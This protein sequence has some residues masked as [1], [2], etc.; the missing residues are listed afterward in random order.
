MLNRKTKLSHAVSS[1]AI[2]GCALGS[3]GLALGGIHPAWAQDT[4]TPAADEGELHT[5]VVVAE[6]KVNSEQKTPIAMSVYRAEQLQSAG[7]TDLR[8]LGAV[9][10]DVQLGGARPVLTMRGIS[11]RDT[12]EIG[13][14][15]VVVATDGTYNNRSYA[16]DASMYD[17]DRVEILRGPQ[18]TLYGRNANGGLINIITNKPTEKREAEA[19]VDVGN[20]HALRL[21]AVLNIPLSETVQMRVAATTKYHQGYLNN[22]PLSADDEDT[23]SA[24]LSLAFQ[25]SREFQGLLTVQQTSRGGVGPGYR[26]LPY[27]YN[28]DA[29]VSHN[30]PVF[31]ADPRTFDVPTMQFLKLND[32][33]LRWNFSYD[34]PSVQISYIGGYDLIAYHVAADSSASSGKPDSFTQNEYPKTQNHELRIASRGD[35]NWAWQAGLYYFQERSSLYS[36]ESAPFRQGRYLPTFAFQYDVNSSSKAV[37]GQTSY[38]LSDTLKVTGGVRHSADQKRRDGYFDFAT[39]TN[40]PLNYFYVPQHSTGSWSKAIWHAGVDWNPAKQ[41]LIYGKYDTG[42]KAGGFTDISPYGPES[43]KGFE[44]GGKIR[45]LNNRA[46]LNLSTFS[47][48]YTGQQVSETIRLD[49]GQTGTNIVNAGRTKIQGMEG[50][51]Q[52]RIEP[53]GKINLSLAYLHARFADFLIA[54]STGR[55]VQLSGNRPPQSP[56][57]AL[58]LGLEHQWGTGRG[59]L[60]GKLDVK[61]LS[62]QHFTFFNY[63]DDLQKAYG[64]I[65]IAATYAPYGSKWSVQ[66]YVRN[67]GDKLAFTQAE[68]SG[69]ANSYRYGFIRPRTWGLKTAFYW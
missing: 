14:P 17:I 23:G 53:L 55:N 24:R 13:D 47:Y 30:M 67:L 9:A 15:A 37:F 51:L 44:V 65:D 8:S 25:P 59:N 2:L 62:A 7:I 58:G 52:A 40:E 54:D 4:A 33:L 57:L 18:G 66:F 49:N 29:S 36:Y 60:V 20:Y 56:T 64:N 41:I 3:L 12:T 63:A 6:K 19:S 11:S 21:N 45:F 16:L 27:V 35:T 46:Q 32:K 38:K 61:Y 1:P 68:E 69:F 10:P 39:N 34:F 28:A 5:I 31:P 26:D 22:G 42:Y 48:A 50:D 43:V